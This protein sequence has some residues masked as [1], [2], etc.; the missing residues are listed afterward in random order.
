VK[1]VVRAEAEFPAEGVPF[2][3]IL[4]IEDP[5]ASRPIFQEIRRQL[6]SNRVELNDIKTAVRLRPQGR[7]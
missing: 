7:R 6:I 4:T 3:L 1:S 5:D 2:S